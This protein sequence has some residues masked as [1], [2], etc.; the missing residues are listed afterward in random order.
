MAHHVHQLTRFCQII[1]YTHP[2][3]QPPQQ[4]A[5]FSTLLSCRLQCNCGRFRACVFRHGAHGSENLWMLSPLG[6]YKTLFPCSGSL[7]RLVLRLAAT[8]TCLTTLYCYTNEYS[9]I[10]CRTCIRPSIMLCRGDELRIAKSTAR[11]AT[12]IMM[13][14]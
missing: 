8:F 10:V 9:C 14:A 2:K 4:F 11:I 6:E 5:P 7:A 3:K 13:V 12:V 1:Y